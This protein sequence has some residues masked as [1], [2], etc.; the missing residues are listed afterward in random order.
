[1]APV[2]T[3][4]S[5]LAIQWEYKVLLRGAGSG[6]AIPGPKRRN[7]RACHQGSRGNN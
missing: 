3:T 2:A 7:N 6:E 1:V 4:T 5:R